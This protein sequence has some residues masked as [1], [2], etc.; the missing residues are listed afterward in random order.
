MPTAMAGIRFSREFFDNILDEM[1]LQIGFSCRTCRKFQLLSDL[2]WV[3]YEVFETL[4]L[5]VPKLFFK[6]GITTVKVYLILM[7]IM[8]YR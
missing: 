6:S 1:K 4:H 3:E 2:A 7:Y 8:S 5:L